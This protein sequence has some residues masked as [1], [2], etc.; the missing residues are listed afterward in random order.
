M[1]IYLMGLRGSGKSTV[2]R[3]LA[4]R[5]GGVFV[6]LDDLTPG[7][8][9]CATAAE[10][11]RTKG[12]PAFRAAEREAL[13]DPRVGAAAVVGLGGGTPT[14]QASAEELRKRVGA[15][16]HLVYLRASVDTLRARLAA[17]DLSKRPSLTG[18]DPLA[19]VAAVWAKRDPIYL[20]LATAIVEVDGRTEAE[21]VERVLSAGG[22]G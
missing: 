3:L 10:A 15:G 5:V 18:A 19:E 17:T 7:V 8:L 11:L 21:V 4:A 9:R 13:D 14:H 22:R 12:E 20:G 2:G 16:D 1:T 6:D